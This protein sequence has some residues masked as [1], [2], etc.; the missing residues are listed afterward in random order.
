MKMNY[1]KFISF[2]NNLG[3]RKKTDEKFV[4]IENGEIGGTYWVLFIER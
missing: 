3:I 2:L 1:K 4:N